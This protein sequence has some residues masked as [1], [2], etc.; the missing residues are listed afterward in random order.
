MFMS[1]PARLAMRGTEK[2]AMKYYDDG[3]KV[4]AIALGALSSRRMT[5]RA[6]ELNLP[7]S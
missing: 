5:D 6:R 3:G 2:K 1:Q 4:R 7:A